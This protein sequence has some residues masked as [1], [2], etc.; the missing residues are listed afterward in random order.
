VVD[1][2]WTSSVAAV[3]DAGDMVRGTAFFVGDDVALTCAHVVAAASNG[4]IRLRR[5]GSTDPE[6]VLDYDLDE[7]LDLALVRVPPKP[8]SARLAI[9]NAPSP[10]GR[11]L[12]SHGFPRDH[13][14]S[15]YPDGFP[16]VPAALAGLTL[17][18]W[19]GQPVEQLILAGS[20]FEQGFSGAPALDSE[21]GR[22]AG[23]LTKFE[24]SRKK[25]YAIPAKVV[26][27]RW[28]GLPTDS[29]AVGPRY[30]DLTRVLDAVAPVA[31]S[32]F[33]PAS[34]HCVVVA[35]EADP[36]Q[37]LGAV[38][39][40]ALARPQ[41]VDIW[42]A[43]AAAANGRRLLS[44]Q[45]RELG[46][47]YI[48]EKVTQASFGVLDA[49]ASFESLSTTTRLL[50]EADLV[51]FDVTGFE[52]GIMLLA[53]I[54]AAT[55]RGVTIS[56]HGGGWQEGQPLNRPFNLSD[57][58]LSSHTPSSELTVGPDPRLD[59][60]TA[61]IRLGFEQCARQPH[62]L[63]L[64][65]Y[66]ALRR[67]GSQEAAWASI[68]LEEE[69]LVLCPYH[70][71]YFS[72]WN[73]LRRR[74]Q[75]AFSVAGAQTTLARLQ[76]IATP[77]LV[78]QTLYERVRRCAACV[79]DW[80]FTSPSTFLELGV[81]LVA[82][83]WGAVQIA[84]KSWLAA[85]TDPNGDIVPVVGQVQLM[86]NLFNPLVYDGKP[87][88]S[89]G[90]LIA[91]QLISIREQVQG[92]SD[93]PVRQAAI[94]ALARIDERLPDPDQMLREDA[95]SLNHLGR[96]R[97]NVPQ[98]LFYEA[99][100]IK[101]DQERAALERRLA[102]WLYLEH[103]VRAGELLDEDPRKALWLELGET[104]VA[105]LYVTGED[106]D[107]EL[108]ARIEE[109]VPPSLD[110]LERTVTLNRRKG[111]ALATR[112]NR[113]GAIE[114]Y[115]NAITGADEALQLLGV[116]A[117]MDADS[118]AAM[119][120]KTAQDAAE[121]L[122]I[123]GGLLRRAGELGDDKA[124]A[125][126]LLSYRL[127]A[128]IETALNLPATYNRSNAIK[129]ALISGEATLQE[130]RDDLLSLRD[131]LERRLATDEQ[132]ADDAWIW[133]DLGDTE[134]LLGQERSAFSA[135]AT[136]ADKARTDSP[137][138]TLNVLRELVE[139]L[140]EHEDQGA[141]ALEAALDRVEDLLQSR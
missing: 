12:I 51:L 76:E 59:R 124:H 137:A 94:K 20:D 6:D 103:R 23:V 30:D 19:R 80:T 61:R 125:E 55:R 1:P 77:Q 31:W 32:E 106:A 24:S 48:T 73:E 90:R 101:A 122:G 110:R 119:E 86:K 7:G 139:T 85:P 82:S 34:L 99:T 64:P 102:A 74:V 29:T 120:E 25:A 71:R 118:R 63:D 116:A 104:A 68:P 135:Y 95:D 35:S 22:V 108:A 134:L 97:S 62:Y 45:V 87:D 28:P 115:R 14:I 40:E 112:G 46:S 100:E 9:D 113:E 18:N 127:G 65:V 70:R 88:Q 123:R 81:R 52:P 60:L 129:L 57:L 138:A 111:D 78:S 33:D 132:A 83:P 10:I 13:S 15:M 75:Q 121:W 49:F 69:V 117:D 36:D 11:Q 136:F 140:K 130:Q 53:G 2:D 38:L 39:A 92:R 105:D 126:A 89:V 96:T 50:V 41:S 84:D 5:I 109:K 72:T 21:S 107:V 79:A 17:V 44:G 56:S 42:N 58:S 67:L 3:V 128:E 133:A 4:S 141:P 98:A 91:E 54:R 66:D 37:E 114:A 27:L 131:V 47:A 8:G 93:H 43:F 16:M 26:Q